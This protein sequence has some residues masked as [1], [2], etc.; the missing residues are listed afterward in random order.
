[1]TILTRK[2]SEFD[3]GGDLAP[4]DTTVGLLSAVNTQ[5]SNPMPLLTPGSTPDRPAIS[6][7]IYYRLRFNTTLQLYEY[8]NPV[9]VAWVQLTTGN[10][11]PW[12]VITAASA[13]LVAGE[14]FITN[15]GTLITLTLPSTATVGTRI[16][17]QSTNTGN[18]R[19]A[20]NAG[21]IIHFGM[22]NSST[23]VTGYIESTQVYSSLVLLCTVADTDWTLFGGPQGIFTFN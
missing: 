16:L 15:A 10:D 20:Q 23:G 2:F 22:Q 3:N 19:I 11:I 4:A 17:V 21:Q 14:G 5:F 18:F 7:S 6:S 1:M 9:A 12:N 13:N 8:Y